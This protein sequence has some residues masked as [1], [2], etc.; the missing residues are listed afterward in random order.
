MTLVNKGYSPQ[1]NMSSFNGYLHSMV[2]DAYEENNDEVKVR[3]LQKRRA[4]PM[5]PLPPLKTNHLI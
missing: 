3:I 5:I 2:D 4:I 1:E